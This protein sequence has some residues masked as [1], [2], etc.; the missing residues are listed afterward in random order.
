MEVSE[1]YWE[2]IQHTAN[3]LEICILGCFFYRFVKPFLP[4]KRNTKSVAVVYIIVMLILYMFPQDAWGGSITAAIGSIAVFTVMCF[5]D[6]RNIEQKIF[7]ASIF[8]LLDWLAW[9][10]VVALWNTSYDITDMIPAV[11]ESYQIQFESYVIRQVCWLI[12]E[13]L[14]MEVL[15]RLL[16]RAYAYKAENMTK[17]ELVLMMAPTLSLISGRLLFRYFV[18]VYEMDLKQYVWNN[19]H[20][21]N[22]V[23]FIHQII[24]FAAL[25]TVIVIY[26]NIKESQRNEIEEKVLARQIEDMKAHISE[27]EILYRDIRGM[28]HDM[29]NHVMVLERLYGDNADAGEYVAQLKEQMNDMVLSVKAKSGNPITDVILT[30]K[31]KEAQEWG[32][33][34]DYDFH[35][36]E[37]KGLNAFDVSVILNNA[38]SN[39]IEAARE[40]DEPYVKLSSYRKNNAYMIEIRNSMTGTRTI[41]E[42]SGL[43]VTTKLDGM[44]GFG[45]SNIRK[46]AQKYYGDIH[47]EQDGKEFVLTVMLILGEFK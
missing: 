25:L 32:I 12:I 17:K 9:G 6:K 47:I 24:S 14:T 26:R 45:L 46:V 13:S 3:I 33:T 16:H 7:L 4:E 36:P 19:H 21:Y 23:L 34:F 1:V 8:Y 27:V 5:I 15:I 22:M 30:E 39:A 44:H 2:V 43:P 37:N 28:K 29:A 31:E 42:G 35:Y 10:V 11:R 41:D 20:S 18:N 40:C 38:L